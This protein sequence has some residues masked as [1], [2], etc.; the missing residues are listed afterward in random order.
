MFDMANEEAALKAHRIITAGFRF[1]IEVLM[2]GK[3][4]ATIGDDNADWAFAIHSNGPGLDV[5][6]NKMIMD[7]DVDAMKARSDAMNVD[8]ASNEQTPTVTDWNR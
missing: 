1:E 4:S 6:I 8:P 3:V 7:F 5:A 2:D